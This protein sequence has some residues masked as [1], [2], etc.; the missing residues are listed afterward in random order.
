MLAARMIAVVL[1]LVSAGCGG[2]SGEPAPG[3]GHD[4]TLVVTYMRPLSEGG[5]T[6]GFDLLHDGGDAV[7]GSMPARPVDGVLRVANPV[8]RRA[9]PGCSHTARDRLTFVCWESARTRT[10]CQRTG[11]ARHATRPPTRTA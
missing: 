7:I 5:H 2:E 4:V 10:E 6:A 8:R 9:R 3:S 1:A 11:C